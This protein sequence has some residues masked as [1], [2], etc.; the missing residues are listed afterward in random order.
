MSVLSTSALTFASVRQARGRG[1]SASE[2]VAEACRCAQE[3]AGDG[4]FTALV[5]PVDAADRAGK[6]QR[7]A[8]S[9]EHL[10]LLGIA[11]AVKDNIHVAGMATTSNCPGLCIMPEETAH[12]VQL[13][14]QAG[15]VLI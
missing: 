4:V 3:A 7:R 5:P 12:A 6:L 9:G 1:A 14:E 2:L 13:L 10:P 15:A 8:D 11:F